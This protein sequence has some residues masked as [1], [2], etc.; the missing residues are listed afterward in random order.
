[1]NEFI[2]QTLHMVVQE[3]TTAAGVHW[4]VMFELPASIDAE[5]RLATWQW[6]SQPGLASLPVRVVRLFDH[7]R[8]YL[9]YEGP[10]SGDRGSVR[11]VDKGT[12]VP[13]C[14]EPDRW[15]VAI[16]SNHLRAQWL[17]EREDSSS[18]EQWWRVSYDKL[19]A[20]G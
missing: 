1:M 12:Y 2:A 19:S 10:I 9:N 8:V 13:L 20:D 14:T 16:V 15:Q 17:L 7:R 6:P 11:I 4:D 5:Q 3:H 18:R